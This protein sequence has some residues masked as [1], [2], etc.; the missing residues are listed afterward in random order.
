MR[1]AAIVLTATGLVT[2]WGAVC[3][4]AQQAPKP[5]PEAALIA[6][7]VAAAPAAVAKDATVVVVESGGKLRTLREGQGAF[8]CIPDDPNTPGHDPMC[9]PKWPGMA[10]G[11]AGTRKAAGRKNMAGLH[12]HRRLG[13]QH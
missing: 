13:R 8:T 1:F 12:A 9:L 10:Q 4:L 6:N 7:A 3:A 5:K 2:G 11:I